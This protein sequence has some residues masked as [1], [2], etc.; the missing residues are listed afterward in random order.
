M[1]RRLEW[2]RGINSAHSAHSAQ[3]LPTLR[4]T[5]RLRYQVMNKLLLFYF[6]LY[7]RLLLGLTGDQRCKRIEA[8]IGGECEPR[9]RWSGGEQG[10]SA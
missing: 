9:E 6:R 5:K 8:A 10:G 7:F 4:S 3:H 2:L 1:D